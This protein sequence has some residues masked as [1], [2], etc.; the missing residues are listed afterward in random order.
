MPRER[1]AGRQ[2]LGLERVETS[3]PEVAGIEGGHQGHLVDEPTARGIEDDGAPR[4]EGEFPC[5]DEVARLRAERHMKR[6]DVRP[7]QAFVQGFD[8]LDIRLALRHGILDENMHA[9]RAC[10][11]RHLVS[12][13]PVADD[14]KRSAA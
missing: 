10:T 7:S 3:G 14:Q 8:N 11:R 12:D 9:E 1:A 13:P 6:Q 4:Q 5:T 2:R